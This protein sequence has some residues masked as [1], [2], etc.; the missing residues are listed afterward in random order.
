MAKIETGV[1]RLVELVSQEKKI[2]IDDAAKKLGISKV[3]I[4]EWADFLEEEK[5]ISIEYSF[6]KT[7]LVERKLSS[8]E[9]KEKRKEYS[10][11]KDAFVRKVEGGLRSLDQD[12]LGM[13]KIK[14]EFDLL[15]KEIGSEIDKVRT[16]VQQLEKYEYLKKNIDK[17]IEKQVSEF[18]TLLDQA[19]R[20]IDKE[21]RRHQ[22]I[23][24]AL[25][26]EKRELQVK[27]HRILG[28]EEKEKEL[29]SRVES[30][31]ALT[32]DLEK[33]ISNE[34]SSISASKNRI[35]NLQNAV[36]DIEASVLKK[37]SSVQP[38]L[39]KAKKHEDQILKLQQDI[40]DKARKKTEEIQGEAR[41]GGNI[42][43][44]FEKFFEKKAEVDN[45][46]V[47]L[48]KEKTDLQNDFENLKKK[49]LAFDIATKSNSV[50][51]HVKDLE[52]D[53]EEVN[54]KRDKF[55]TDLEKLIKLVKG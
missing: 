41:Q 14:S 54:K 35:Y 13:E 20:E 28:H 5:I 47:Q 44:N 52:S 16:E 9:I 21:Q 33:S 36:K 29:M 55:K 45:L 22:E 53:M 7:F 30:I 34:K 40:L 43:A 46:I 49:A 25:E 3:V 50:T 1:D 32:K 31:L 17:D 42:V 23:L 26:V 27:E 11:E 19:H 18:R 12:A 51:T 8:G 38:L 6:N 15:K 2:S 39:D 37:K 4:Q 48:E 10:T 24:E